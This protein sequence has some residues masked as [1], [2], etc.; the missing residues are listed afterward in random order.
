MFANNL[1]IQW[2]GVRAEVYLSA[3]TV[4]NFSNNTEP[5]TFLYVL[6]HKFSIWDSDSGGAASVTLQQLDY[7]DPSG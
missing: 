2:G 5:W 7:Y 4:C 6:K 1:F 3:F